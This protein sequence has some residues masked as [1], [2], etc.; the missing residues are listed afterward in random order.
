MTVKMLNTK[1]F[2]LIVALFAAFFAAGS[3][4]A[5]NL[6]G[7]HEEQA[8]KIFNSLM[9]PF[10][11]G[12][13]L[14][15]CPSG[16]AHELKEKVRARLD[17]GESTDEIQASL[18]SIYGDEILAAPPFRHFGVWAW[19]T[20]GIFLVV[21]VLGILVWIRSRRDQEQIEPIISIDSETEERIRREMQE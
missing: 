10:C 7:S 14:Q 8:N 6:V 12:R 17:A 5:E 21:G 11:P 18:V 20:P 13:L 15:D 16:S 1:R 4:N 19:L 9:S 3:L 2:V